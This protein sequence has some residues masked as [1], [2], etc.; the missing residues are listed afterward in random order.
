MLIAC[1]IN[2]VSKRNLF[3]KKH[4]RIIQV[5]PRGQKKPGQHGLQFFALDGTNFSNELFANELAFG[6][7]Q[8]QPDW[9]PGAHEMWLQ[10]LLIL[11]MRLLPKFLTYNSI[12]ALLHIIATNRPAYIIYYYYFKIFIGHSL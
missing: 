12:S 9:H 7:E 2:L 5:R 11:V 1:I 3:G 8:A 10:F 6:V 4:L